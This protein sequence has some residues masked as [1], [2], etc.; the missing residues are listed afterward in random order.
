MHPRNE[1]GGEL[2]VVGCDKVQIH[3]KDCPHRVDVFFKKKRGPAPCDPHHHHH[4]DE[5]QW[6]LHQGFHG[7]H[8]RYTLNIE[9]D[10]REIRE[11]VWLVYY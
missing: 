10:V 7:H 1:Q 9:W 6:K 8:H 11:I 2:V 5:L 4:V 3:L